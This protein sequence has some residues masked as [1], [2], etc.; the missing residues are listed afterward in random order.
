MSKGEVDIIIVGADRVATNG[1]IANKVGTLEKAVLAREFGIPFYVAFPKTTY[2]PQC[3]DGKSIPI[4]ERSGSEIL[5][6]YGMPIVP[7]GSLGFNPA[8]DVTPSRFITGY[9][10]ED[11]ILSSEDLK[12]K[13]TG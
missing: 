5:E 12:E 4:E 3:P 10:T 9:I 1:D 6:I 11:G 13:G 7:E 8:F 2:D